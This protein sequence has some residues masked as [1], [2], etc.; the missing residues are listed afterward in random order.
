MSR[1][2]FILFPNYF[3]MRITITRLT[4]FILLILGVVPMAHAQ[5]DRWPGF[6]KNYEIGYGYSSTWGTHQQIVKAVRS[7]GKLYDTTISSN[8]SSNHGFSAQSGTSVTLKRLGRVSTLALGISAN[9]NIYTWNYPSSSGAV[10]SDSGVKFDYG[11][12][13]LFTGATM[14]AGLALS[15]DFKF[16]AEAMMD[17]HYHWSWTGGIGVFPS[18][19]LTA[20]VDNA[21]MTFGLQPFIKTEV[22]WRGPIVAKLRLLYAFGN[23][24][25]L[26]VANKDGL[27]G[28][29][30]STYTTKLT[31]NGNF[32][33]SLVLLP[34]SWT[35]KK[36]MWYNSN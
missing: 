14:N 36:S 35:Y 33:V 1:L 26:N 8:V 4:L 29:P 9:Y 21:D 6:I 2:H 3:S 11:S 5:F 22:G 16:G 19:N 28:I 32:T 27:Y 17:K 18:I 31:G 15:A 25:Y 12:G 24:P 23:V 20:D 7:D 10:L 13:A 30:N 34:F